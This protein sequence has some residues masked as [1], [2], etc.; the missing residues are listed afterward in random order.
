MLF[1][2]LLFLL[3]DIL[4][5]RRAHYIFHYKLNHLFSLLVLNLQDSPLFLV[6]YEAY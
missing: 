6:K 4:F 1:Q 5:L 3:Q 2:H